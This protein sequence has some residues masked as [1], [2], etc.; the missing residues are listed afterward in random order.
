VT[1]DAHDNES[2]VERVE[3]YAAGALLGTL[4]AAPYGFEVNTWEYENGSLALEARAYD[5]KGNMGTA[6]RTVQVLNAAAPDMW[7]YQD[8]FEN[9]WAD[10]SWGGSADVSN[11]SP[12]H[13]GSASIAFT[14]SAQWGAFSTDTMLYGGAFSGIEL[15]LNGGDSPEDI[16]F[17]LEGGGRYGTVPNVTTTG[18]WQQV[19]LDM[20]VLN[21]YGDPF[22]RIDLQSS[23]MGGNVFYVDDIRLVGGE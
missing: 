9:G 14:P 16:G 20:S 12:V 17:A 1:V 3:L 23:G 8:A 21:P 22:N 18:S 4:D 2:L 19:L 7:I 5:L 11:A 15:Y 10:W 6:T 13:A